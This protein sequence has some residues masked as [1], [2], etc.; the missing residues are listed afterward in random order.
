MA[1][2]PPPAAA[3]PILDGLSVLA[4]RYDVLFCDVWGVVH[5]GVAE[6]PEAGAALEKFRAAGGVVVLL[7]NAPVPRASVERVLGQKQVRRSA[8][9]AIVSSG[10]ATRAWLEKL[11]RGGVYYIGPD[12]HQPLLAG[13]QVRSAPLESA[14]VAVVTGLHDEARETAENYR[15]M[16]E[17][18]LAHGLTLICANPDRAVHVGE[19]LLPCAGVI[20]DLYEEMGGKVVWA[21]KPYPPIYEL[22]LAEATR[23]RGAATKER[24]LMIGDSVKTD[25]AGAKSFGVDAL[26]IAQGIH[27]EHFG[28]EADEEKL[29]ELLR[30]NG[31]A[32]IGAMDGLRW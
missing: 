23:L 30:R 32:A 12:R 26:F 28:G 5:N 21:G 9:D 17:K 16:M 11:G 4:G 14:S 22:A 15:P 20:G 25:L 19:R 13:A 6:Y 31:V 8:W 7:T 1:T 29:G 18:L 27:R 24:V 10:D 3:I 2:T